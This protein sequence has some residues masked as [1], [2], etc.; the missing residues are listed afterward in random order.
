MGLTKDDV[1]KEATSNA[2]FK[3]ELLSSFKDDFLAGLKA[4]GVII[5]KPDEEKEFIANYEKTVIPEKVNAQIGEKVKAVHEQYDND[6]FE[7]TGEKKQPNEKTY[8]F[9]KRK[10][11]DL[12]KAK[13]T[14]ENKVILEQLEQ[15]QKELEK[16]KDYVPKEELTK[17]QEKYFT[18]SINN[19]LS[20]SL[21]TKAIA[22]PAHIT[23]EKAKQ[24]YAASQRSMI[25]TDFLKRFT[26]KT[27]NE[28][29]IVYY[30][31]DKLLTNPHNAKPLTEDEIISKYYPA[32]FAPET[33][34][35]TGA[36]SGKGGAGG[37]KDVNEAS[38]KSKQEVI[39]Y[40]KKKFEPQGIKQGSKK[41]NDEY[42]RIVTDYAI[43]E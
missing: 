18:D 37:T 15:A 12:K 35:K 5:R 27:D 13:P 8:D 24:E 6:L 33:K 9:L 22:V 29:N 16:R 20:G 34:A 32:Y 26:A 42:T 11:S 25:Q 31:G 36:G 10:I 40:L 43:T 7:C 38:L 41:F 4:E 23:E 1:L 21:S 2:T 28:G 19:K 3:T 30:E 14:E 17:L 39:D